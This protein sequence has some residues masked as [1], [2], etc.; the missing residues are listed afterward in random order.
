MKKMSLAKVALTTNPETD[1][2]G[3][4]HQPRVSCPNT[5]KGIWLWR[6]ALSLADLDVDQVYANCKHA[7]TYDWADKLTIPQLETVARLKK[8]LRAHR[9]QLATK[10]VGTH[11]SRKNFGAYLKETFGLVRSERHEVYTLTANGAT[12]PDAVKQVLSQRNDKVAPEGKVWVAVCCHRHYARGSHALN[13]IHAH[14]CASWVEAQNYA[15]SY[16]CG[17]H[18]W[19]T[20]ELRDKAIDCCHTCGK[21][22]PLPLPGHASICKDCSDAWPRVSR[23]EMRELEEVEAAEDA[24]D[25]GEEAYA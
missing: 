6:R 1:L 12:T 7:W 8:H 13:S 11:D 9:S 10:P 21:P 2:L 22:M 15:D 3:R 24:G 4:K 18:G 19:A 14:S 5:G 16:H 17:K 23:Q 25:F 20:V